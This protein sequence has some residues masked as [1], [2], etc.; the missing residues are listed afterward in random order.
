MSIRVDC[1]DNKQ[2]NNLFVS[3]R[4][5]KIN[6]ATVVKDKS[7]CTQEEVEWSCYEVIHPTVPLMDYLA[8]HSR[9]EDLKV[10]VD[11]SNLQ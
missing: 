5:C 1:A 6:T 7:C 3:L 9:V 8:N 4:S 10:Q 2:Q 11:E